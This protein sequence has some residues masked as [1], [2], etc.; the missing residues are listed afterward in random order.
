MSIIGDH[1]CPLTTLNC[2]RLPLISGLTRGGPFYVLLAGSFGHLAGGW[3]WWWWELGCPLVIDWNISQHHHGWSSLRKL[4][5]S[6]FLQLVTCL[7]IRLRQLV[8]V[9]WN[10][11]SISKPHWKSFL[12]SSLRFRQFFVPISECG[13]VLFNVH[14]CYTSLGKI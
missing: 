8:S 10:I 2:W 4:P 6:Q 13:N 11:R 3:P 5:W 7:L 14:D 12:S 1:H 9:E